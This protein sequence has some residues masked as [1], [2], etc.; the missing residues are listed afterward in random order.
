MARRKG[1]WKIGKS[2]DTKGKGKGV[3]SLEES[4]EQAKEG[5]A[6]GEEIQ[7]IF[8]LDAGKAA[9]RGSIKG[10]KQANPGKGTGSTESFIRHVLTN[11]KAEIATKQSQLLKGRSAR[12]EEVRGTARMCEQVKA[13]A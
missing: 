8:A 1:T 7:A 9:S 11:L 5:G 10:G 3:K 6:D 4:G 2:Q 12:F 13:H